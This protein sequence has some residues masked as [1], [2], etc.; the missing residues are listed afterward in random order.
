[1][2]L[3]RKNILLIYLG[4]IFI[5]SFFGVL[6]TFAQTGCA[7]GSLG[8]NTPTTVVTLP[9]PLGTTSTVMDLLK[10]IVDFLL[11]IASPIAAIMIIWGAFQILFA[12]GDT[13]KFATGKRTILYTVIGLAVILVGWGFVSIIED[14]LK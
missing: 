3:S 14:V 7:P 12:A 13:E 1:M 4:L 5:F 10:K 8:C 11:V 6:N 2:T 9:N